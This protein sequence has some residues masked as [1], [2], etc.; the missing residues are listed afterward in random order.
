MSPG[1]KYF[2]M[3]G[4]NQNIT[5]IPSNMKM[6]KQPLD[7]A[8]WV[9]RSESYL[10]VVNGNEEETQQVKKQRQPTTQPWRVEE[11]KNSSCE[12]EI[13]LQK[14]HIVKGRLEE[15][16]ANLN[17]EDGPS[18]VEGLLSIPQKRSSR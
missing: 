10:G 12:T 14:N 18:E 15:N 7:L 13:G 2:K 9:F 1:K 17:M 11:R 5:G 4:I 6:A 8:T 16:K 3:A